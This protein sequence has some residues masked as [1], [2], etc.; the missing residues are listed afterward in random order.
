MD[1]LGMNILIHVHQGVRAPLAGRVGIHGEMAAA[2]KGRGAWI[3]CR[4][5]APMVLVLGRFG[6]VLHLGDVVRLMQDVM[7]C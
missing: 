6:Q 2:I 4:G 1:L 3:A 5:R 7:S